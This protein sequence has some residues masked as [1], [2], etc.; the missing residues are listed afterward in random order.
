MNLLAERPE[1]NAYG[2]E[3]WGFES[4]RARNQTLES[5]AHSVATSAVSALPSSEC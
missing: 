2:S 3:G 5:A 1:P 4:L